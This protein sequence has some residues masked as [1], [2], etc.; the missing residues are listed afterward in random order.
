M[1]V[2]KYHIALFGSN[3][4]L[5]MGCLV[6]AIVLLCSSSIS[7][8]IIFLCPSLYWGVMSWF[9]FKSAIL[10]VD[11]YKKEVESDGKEQVETV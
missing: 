5:C 7:L 9:Y 2:I 3:C 11:E 10:S 8:G 4:A 1:K 6:Y